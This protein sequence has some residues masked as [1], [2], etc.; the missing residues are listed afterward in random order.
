MSEMDYNNLA[1]TLGPQ[2][3]QETKMMLKAMP[4]SDRAEYIKQMSS[5]VENHYSDSTMQIRSMLTNDLG[6]TEDL[7]ANNLVF[8]PPSPLGGHRYQIPEVDALPSKVPFSN[9]YITAP[10]STPSA[11]VPPSPTP[12][13]QWSEAEVAAAEAQLHKD[14]HFI[15]GRDDLEFE[16]N[17]KLH[18]DY[19]NE[20]PT[21]PEE[22]PFETQP[23]VPEPTWDYE[24]T[25]VLDRLEP[26]QKASLGRAPTSRHKEML[27]EEYLGAVP[28]GG[29]PTTTPI[30][31]T[32]TQGPVGP[33]GQ[34]DLNPPPPGAQTGVVF[35]NGNT[36]S[37][38][39]PPKPVDLQ[40]PPKTDYEPSVGQQI[41]RYAPWVLG[42]GGLAALAATAY[43]G[44]REEDEEEDEYTT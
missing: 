19:V 15:G 11:F 42:A 13:K 14:E 32:G 8:S 27:L 28:A 2:N 24:D 44:V 41:M 38:L 36:G 1:R 21:L 39:P 16:R 40:P 30:V 10:S 9:S 18:E 33:V 26:W 4:P 5:M 20:L 37:F 34:L 22:V 6:I 3:I 17:K 31:S 23:F 35:P 29:P 7:L 43:D 12:H 25:T